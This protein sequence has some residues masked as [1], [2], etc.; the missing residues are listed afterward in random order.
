MT[1][2][3]TSGAPTKNLLLFT[4]PL[5]IGNLFQQLYNIV[6]MVIVGR[7]LSPTAYA[8]VGSVGSL[9][10][11]ASGAMSALAVGFS[12]VTARYFG[13]EDAEGVKRSFAG[14]MKL[15][16]FI[17][18][19]FAAVCITVARPVLEMLQ[20]PA[21]IL[22]RSYRYLIWILIGLVT[23]VFYHLLANVLRA[24]GDSKTP[25][26]FQV[27]ACVANIIL[28][29]VLIVVCG[30]DTDG[31]GLATVLAQF[32]SV[33]LCAWRIWRKY[34]ALHVQRH[35]FV[36]DAAMTKD[37]LRTAVP[38]ACLNM[39]LSSGGIMVQTTTNRMGTLYV[40]A[41]TTGS[42][43]E[44]IIIQPMMSLSSALSVFA[45]QNYGAKQYGRV[46]QGV[47]SALLL[48]YVWY[49]IE[50]SVVVLLGRPIMRLLA[51]AVTEDVVNN[52]YQ[53]AVI[54]ALLSA[55]LV[56]V[57]M[58]K[59]AL[60]ATDRPLW[61]MISG[62]TEIISRMGLSVLTILWMHTARLG[63]PIGEQTGYAIMCFADPGA[64]LIC[65]LTVLPAFIGMVR[66]FR[67]KKIEE[68]VEQQGGELCTI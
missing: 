15:A 56:P 61:P 8:A 27:I 16:L 3:L 54:T 50:A 32:L 52:A 30:M 36:T 18:V 47:R 41:Q 68:V 23:T 65:L 66:N 64:W 38:M 12:V 51:G 24:L 11:F 40:S 59:C 22:D 19:V 26:Y 62:F 1:N 63:T 13:A 42:R 46:L 45:A 2:N 49:A 35:H 58:F 43:I 25:L 31:A 14:A 21:D 55:L 10:W 9:I 34:P 20:Y 6:D 57:V 39:V 28:D 17:A 48:G 7:V 67:N 4:V 53:Y 5:L 29:V 44:N 33:L 60:Q 37:L